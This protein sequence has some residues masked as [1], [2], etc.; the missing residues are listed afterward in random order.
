VGGFFSLD[1]LASVGLV[2]LSEGD[3]FNEN[4]V[5]FAAGA[6]LGILRESF[7]APGVS[8]SAM[9][10]RVGDV[11]FGDRDL[12]DEQSYF[13]ASSFSVLSLRGVVGKRV[14]FLTASAGIGWDRYKS[15]LRFGVLDPTAL[16]I[17]TRHDFTEDDF[18]TSR[19][20]YFAGLQYTL[21]VL[22]FNLEGGLQAGG[23]N[24]TAPLPAGQTSTTQD[25]AGFLSLAFRLTI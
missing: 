17:V 21:L 11:D 13:I 2:P 15:D 20:V 19:V 16:G 25:K 9:Y 14:L 23:D 3:G 6:R 12:Q 1:I 24:F 7:T 18:E 5:T 8:L 22:S 4:A 10:R